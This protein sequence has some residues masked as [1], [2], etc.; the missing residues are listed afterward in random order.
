MTVLEFSF[1]DKDD[2]QK[3]IK[4]HTIGI[5]DATEDKK[6]WEL[7]TF[8][9]SE[10]YEK[11]MQ[12]YPK[13][14]AGDL[15]EIVP[16]P[17]SRLKFGEAPGG[18]TQSYPKAGEIPKLRVGHTYVIGVYNGAHIGEAEFIYRQK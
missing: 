3:I 14:P 17:V 6:V 13:K 1:H 16:L 12:A 7:N 8:T 4:L 15:P 11:N 10:L 18:F 9:D 5:H 2:F